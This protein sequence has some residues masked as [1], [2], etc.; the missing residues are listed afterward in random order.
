MIAVKQTLQ[1]H[2]ALN[3]PTFMNMML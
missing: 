2:T 3:N 1:T